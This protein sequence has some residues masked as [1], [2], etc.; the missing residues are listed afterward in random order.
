MRRMLLEAAAPEL[1]GELHRSPP[2][3]AGDQPL[4]HLLELRLALGSG[5]PL[6]SA[7]LVRPAG[8]CCV[9]CMEGARERTAQSSQ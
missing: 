3:I 5:R 1:R 4:L 6:W 2:A 8:S 7:S 9:P